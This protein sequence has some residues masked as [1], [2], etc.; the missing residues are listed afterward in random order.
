[1]PHAVTSDGSPDF[2]PG[3]A[4]RC[5]AALILLLA[6][7][8]VPARGE[9]VPAPAAASGG[10]PAAAPGPDSGPPAA[11]EAS[12]EAAPPE[13]AP[14]TEPGHD[15][16]AP[17]GPIAGPAPRET[18]VAG[19]PPPSRPSAVPSFNNDYALLIG[20]HYWDR[21]DDFE[22]AIPA[23]ATGHA[24]RL[25][26]G[27]GDIEISY[28]R[29]VIRRPGWDLFLGGDFGVFAHENKEEYRVTIMPSGR[30]LDGE[31]LARGLYLMPS[32][33]L[34]SGEPAPWRFF[35]GAGAGLVLIDFS[36]QL[37]D[38]MTEDTF[39]R[40]E[41][42]GGYLSLGADRILSRSSISILLRLEAKVMFADFGSLGDFAPGAGRL[43]GPMYLFQVG[44]AVAD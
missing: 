28:H 26:P 5:V 22:P 7:A 13:A 24:G 12:G 36:T 34:F 30:T 41:T 21:V 9:E 20:L 10:T 2:G 25:Q 44:I 17:S 14:A 32:A 1:M 33:K 27:G 18:A 42:L 29:R 23:G 40:E 16:G 31:L 8:A 4:I 19:E 3:A 11:G 6:C 35:V 38:G 37:E 39:F 43:T 15:T